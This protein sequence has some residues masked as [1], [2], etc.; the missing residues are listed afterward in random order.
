MKP[1][2]ESVLFETLSKVLRGL[3]GKTRVLV[4]DEDPDLVRVLQYMMYRDGIE[5]ELAR[6]AE[7]AIRAIPEFHP[8]LIVLDLMQH[9]GDG[10]HLAQWLRSSPDFRELPVFVYSGKELTEEERKRLTVGPTEFFHKKQVTPDDFE[11]R[12]LTTVTQMI[13]IKSGAVARGQSNG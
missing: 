10:F 2:E 4:A 9:N 11:Q 1:L 7:D 13:P 3:P 5:V 12:V 8:D 6:S